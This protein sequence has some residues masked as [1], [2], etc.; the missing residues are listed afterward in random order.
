MAESLAAMGDGTRFSATEEKP[1]TR[2]ASAV[3]RRF[4]PSGRVA[5]TRKNK[6]MELIGL[7]SL[8]FS[9]VSFSS[10]EAQPVLDDFSFRSIG[11][12]VMG[13]RIDAVAAVEDRPWILY[14]GTASG[15][16]WKTTNMGTTWKPVFDEQG[17]SSIGD[18]AVSSSDPATVWVGTGE[19]NNR[20]SSS[21]G[22]G[23]YKSVDGGESWQHM[24]LDETRHIGK[25]VIDPTRPSRVFVA[26]LG[27]LWSASEARGVYRT[28]D[29]GHTWDKVLAIDE[30]TGV[31]TLV[32]DPKNP[33]ALYAA[34]YQRRRTPWGFSG[35]GPGSGLYKTT[36]GGEHWRALTSG[37]PE[38]PL[39]R[40]GIA[41]FPGDPRIVYALVEH[42][43]EGGLYRSDDRGESFRKVNDLNPR[44]MYYSQ[45]LVDPTDAQ[46]VYV[47]GSSFH[48]SEDGGRS[49]TTNRDMTPT[50]DVGVHGDHHALWIDPENPAHLV[51][52]G[53]GGL[54]FS[55]D[56]SR[57]WD[58]IDNLPIAQVYALAFDMEEPYN[59]YFGAQDT[60]SWM[61][62][63]ATRHQIGILNG[64]WRQINF[65][66]GMYQ[67]ADPT[68]ASIVYTESQGGNLV[69]LDRTTGGR[70]VIK[71]HP[72][73]T[74]TRYRFHWTAPL[75][76]SSHDPKRLYFGGNRL[77]VSDDRG[78]S[79]T[80]SSDLTRNEDRDELPIMGQVPDETTLSRHD[81][82]GAW[83]TITTIAESPLDPGTLYVGT[84]DGRIQVTRDSGKSWE[85]V[86]GNVPGVEIARSTIT[87]IVA[88]R[89]ELSRAYVSV[90][91]HR[92]GDF[93]PYVFTTDDFG[94]HWRSIG[95]GLPREGWVNVVL[96]HPE[97]GQVLFAGTET[98]LSVTFDR[99]AAW[100]RMTG[101]LPTVPV[102]DLAFHP[103]EHDLIVGTHGRSIYILDDASPLGRHDPS[104]TEAEL[105]EPRPTTLFLP[106]KHESYGAQRPFVGDDAPYG[107][108][109]TYFLPEPVKEGVRFEI[110]GQT[111][112]RELDGPGRKGF[113]RV[114]WD[115][116]SEAPEGVEGA[117][118][119]LVPPGTYRVVLSAGAV[120]RTTSAELRL[121]PRLSIPPEELERRFA[122][123]TRVNVLRD[124]LQK[125][126]ERV[127]ALRKDTKAIAS[128]LG[129]SASE[130]LRDD[131]TSF[132]DTLK[133]A[134]KPIGGGTRRSF[135]NPDLMARTSRLFGELDGD[136]V[137][138]GTLH[139]P[140]ASQE[141]RLGELEGEAARA[142][143]TLDES[144]SAK[145]PELNERLEVFGPLRLRP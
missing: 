49:F 13:G 106:W 15:G 129:D 134:T 90:D 73:D 76:I 136:A 45:V 112:L 82:V 12:A 97:N 50:Y 38:G 135:R 104:V 92:L 133:D 142:L 117:R 33:E 28:V 116:R 122:F 3:R 22:N 56:R 27:S 108:V 96:E 46:R 61:G 126:L 79:W 107:V 5:A 9:T 144:I 68:D 2:L 40:I 37:L 53:D 31:T 64:D 71:P 128:L 123:L 6:T 98:G 52:G 25:V 10:L 1:M 23:V 84:D 30:D 111:T 139:G 66:D 110:Q 19:P 124:R 80:A 58:K 91:R 47:L 86:E 89:A 8:L 77:F 100:R 48:V 36:D 118:G 16:L 113:N 20:Q 32:M 105:F 121:D 65:G 93:T 34:S 87:R 137:R 85:S 78:A 95:E 11:P 7:F 72:P 67:Q 42:A 14:V 120:T 81:G 83:G 141:A 88:S 101:G 26:A 131:L 57:S 35:G 70:R 63:S 18:V 55:W 119:P 24:G 44:P 60:H 103:R 29:G 138:Q 17:T 140:T 99:G 94:G 43:T 59:V 102:D 41:V 51:L 127:E 21:F 114:V 54:Y 69:R 115:M 62:P 143:E 125:A 4:R 132:R 75:R 109:V 130:E 39:G 74:S 145:L